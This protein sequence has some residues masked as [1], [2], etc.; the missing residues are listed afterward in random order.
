VDNLPNKI[1]EINKMLTD[2]KKYIK[3]LEQRFFKDE[4]SEQEEILKELG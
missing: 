4:D 2:V 3:E 1:E